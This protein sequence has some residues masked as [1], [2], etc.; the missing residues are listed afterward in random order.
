MPRRKAYEGGTIDWTLYDPLLRL[1][2]SEGVKD[3]EMARRLKVK[4]ADVRGR[5]AKLSPLMSPSQPEPSEPQETPRPDDVAEGLPGEMT[6][7]ADTGLAMH[8]GA[9]HKFDALPEGYA[10]VIQPMREYTEAEDEALKESVRLF[11]FIGAI[12]RDQFGRIVD[13]NQRARVARWFGGVCP[14]TI[15]YVRDDAHAVE[16]AT[17]LNLARRHFTPEQRQEIAAS[18]REQGRSYR[19]IAEA[20]HVSH[21]QARA[22]VREAEAKGEPHVVPA[23]VNTPALETNFPMKSPGNDQPLETDFPIM[24]PPKTPKRIKRKGGGTYPDK[25]PA[26]TKP[27]TPKAFDAEDIESQIK[28]LYMDWLRRCEDNNALGVAQAFIKTLSDLAQGRAMQLERVGGK[29]HGKS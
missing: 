3:N 25:R 5:L 9:V 18:L 23:A 8:H 17:Q 27:K 16:I 4:R 7:D 15:T 20:L 10:R 19:Y 24:P 11:G 2:F 14:F 22:D 21:T 28:D 6:G 26:A 13:G 12:V 29:D 1:W